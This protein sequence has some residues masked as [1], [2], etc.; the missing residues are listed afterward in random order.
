MALEQALQKGAETD[1]K[2]TLDILF[3]PVNISADCL[4][5]KIASDGQ[6]NR[7]GMLEMVGAQMLPT[8]P[9]VTE[10]FGCE[11]KAM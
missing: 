1:E 7:C 3:L 11:F 9:Y 8:Y 4:R 10:E 6:R 2:I 5:W